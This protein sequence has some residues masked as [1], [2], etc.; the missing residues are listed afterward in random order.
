MPFYYEMLDLGY[1]CRITDFQCALGISQLRKRPGFLKRR[2]EIA[3]LYDEALA[4]IPGIEPLALRADAL[5]A[6]RSA[7]RRAQSEGKEGAPSD[8][9][10]CSMPCIV[11][12]K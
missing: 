2:R 5:P 1:N 11:K 7:E 8:S 9:T 6:T 3:A 12:V 4:D 10:P